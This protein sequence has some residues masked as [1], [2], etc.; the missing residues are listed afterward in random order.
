MKNYEISVTNYKFPL[1]SLRLITFAGIFLILSFAAKAQIA[2]RGET[3]WTMTQNEPIRDGVVLI[4]NGKI[5]R[6]GAAGQIQIPS[7][8]RV[9]N[10]KVV[11]PGLIDSHTVVGLSGYM[12]QPH[13]QM[14][15]DAS[16]PIQPELR[17]I[18][19][20]NTQERLIEWLR[21]FGVTTIHTGHGPGAAVSGQ[22]MIAKTIGKTV[23]EAAMVPTAMVAATIGDSAMLSGGRAPGTRAKEIAMLRAELLKAT[24]YNRKVDDAKGDALKLPTRE[25]RTEMFGRVLRR[26]L[27]LLVTAHRH[28]DISTALRLAKEFNI[29][30]ILDGAADAHLLINE[31]KA[32]NVPVIVHA[33]MYR[34]GGETGNL[35]MTTA[36]K[37]RQAGI[38]IA[39]Q[40]GF[41]GYVPK[42]RVVLLE[43]GIAAANGLSQRD[44]LGSITIDAAR[45]LGIDAR[46]GSLVAG[47]D[48]DLAMYDGDPL[49]YTTH[50]IGTIINGNVVSQAIR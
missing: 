27:P 45:I 30:L 25:M 6:V 12:N 50:C 29:R 32:A 7:D 42:T 39:L 1:F 17:A 22:T 44:A 19:S 4:R 23:D 46:V 2:V 28:Q 16:A 35:S 48:A 40:S 38:P 47:K 43:A 31:I 11:T 49:E 20:Y 18:D 10:A 41:E 9:I 34:A 15:L 3:V 13:D 26:E 5:E 36:S 8:Y 14:Q 21:E 37:L 33:T 24:D